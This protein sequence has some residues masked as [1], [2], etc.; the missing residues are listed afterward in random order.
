MTHVFPVD[1]FNVPVLLGFLLGA[2]L[3]FLGAGRLMMNLLIVN[4]ET[5]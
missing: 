5:V 3:G 2:L 4:C 1:G